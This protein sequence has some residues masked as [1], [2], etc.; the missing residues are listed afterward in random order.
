MPLNLDLLALQPLPQSLL[1]FLNSLKHLIARDNQNSNCLQFLLNYLVKQ[2]L[3][4]NPSIIIGEGKEPDDIVKYDVKTGI[5]KDKDNNNIVGR[6]DIF[7]NYAISANA[8]NESKNTFDL[9]AYLK[10]KGL[11]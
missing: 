5:Y 2:I 8:Y 6:W 10:Q 4:N 11:K 3:K 1:F 9:G 7:N